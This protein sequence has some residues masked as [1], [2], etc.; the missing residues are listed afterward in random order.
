MHHKPRLAHGMSRTRFYRVWER[1]KYVCTKPNS[2]CYYKYGGMGV[3][4]CKRWHKFENFRDDMYE[5]YLEHVEEYGEKETQIDRI[6]PYGN[7][8]PSNCRWVTILEQA[9]NKRANPSV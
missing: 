7:Y 4:V 1:I 3:E 9:R 2:S 5:S 8:E 6:N